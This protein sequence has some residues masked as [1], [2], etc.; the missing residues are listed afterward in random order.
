MSIVWYN[1]RY[2]RQ[3]LDLCSY[4]NRSD[5]LTFTTSIPTSRGLVY[6]DKGSVLGWLFYEQLKTRRSLVYLY[7]A[8]DHR[9]EGIATLLVKTVL[10]DY[11]E[12][13]ADCDEELVDCQLFLK[14]MGFNGLQQDNGSIEFI[15]SPEMGEF[16]EI[17]RRIMSDA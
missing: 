15:W 9:R 7:V 5:L 8:P 17:M 2:A 10:S 1:S 3:I 14:S 11:I 12:V 6:H 4:W 16:E 13:T